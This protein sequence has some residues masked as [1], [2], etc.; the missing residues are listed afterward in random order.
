MQSLGVGT[1]TSRSD[2]LMRTKLLTLLAAAVLLAPSLAIA[3]IGQTGDADR[4]RDRRER[5]RLARRHGHA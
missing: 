3:Q 5:S 2:S 4:H 1:T